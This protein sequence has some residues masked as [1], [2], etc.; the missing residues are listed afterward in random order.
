MTEHKV[1]LYSNFCVKVDRVSI[2]SKRSEAADNPTSPFS[3]ECLAS[4]SLADP[5]S[6]PTI[7][8]RHASIGCRPM[9]WPLLHLK[10]HLH[11]VYRLSGADHTWDGMQ[12]VPTRSRRTAYPDHYRGSQQPLLDEV[13]ILKNRL[14]PARVQ[15]RLLFRSDCRR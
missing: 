8:P 4:V 11:A 5:L 14:T 10:K 7:L 12:S 9:C 15:F 13:P 6:H 3:C 2:S 1:D